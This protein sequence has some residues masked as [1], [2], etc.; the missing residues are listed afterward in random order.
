MPL[1]VSILRDYSVTCIISRSVS[2]SLLNG[3]S[4]QAEIMESAAPRGKPAGLDRRHRPDGVVQRTAA[5]P[6]IPARDHRAVTAGD[7]RVHEESRHRRVPRQLDAVT[8]GR[9]T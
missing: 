5:P 7:L 2:G 1:S 9:S 8:R 6:R 4:S 3:Y